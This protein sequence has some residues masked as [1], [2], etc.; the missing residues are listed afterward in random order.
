M[1]LFQELYSK[2]RC[3]KTIVPRP[4]AVLCL[5][6]YNH[7]AKKFFGL[8]QKGQKENRVDY[9]TETV[10]YPCIQMEKGSVAFGS[11]SLSSWISLHFMQ[12]FYV[13][14]VF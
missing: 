2:S 13:C 6:L 9:E 11:I 3:G 10:F 14:D 7:L 4:S 1:N 5:F 8:L 12:E